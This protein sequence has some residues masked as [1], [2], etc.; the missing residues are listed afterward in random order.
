MLS[1]SAGPVAPADRIGS[2]DVALIMRACD[3]SGR[4]LSPDRPATKSDASFIYQAFGTGDGEGQGMGAAG[5]LW[6]TY[7][8]VSSSRYASKLTTIRQESLLGRKCF[9][10]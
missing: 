9:L 7:A 4:L 10:A 8:T 5:Q 1:F 3:A 2:S 6:S